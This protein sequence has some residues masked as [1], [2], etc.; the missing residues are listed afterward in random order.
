MA[1]STIPLALLTGLLFASPPPAPPLTV[2]LDGDG[3]AEQVTAVAKKKKARIEIRAAAGGKVLAEAELPAPKGKSAGVAEITLS[4]GSL[5]S[6]GA[7]LEAAA[8]SG[9]EECRSLWRYR[10]RALS[11]VPIASTAVAECGPAGEWSYGWDQGSGDAPAEYRRERT[12]QSAGGPNHRVESFRY[13]GFRLEPDPSRSRS[14][15]RGIAIPAWYAETIY[16]RSGLEGL[17]AHYDLSELKRSARLRILTDR[18]AGVFSVRIQ[19]PSSPQPE[20]V[21]PVTASRPGEEPNEVILTLGEDQPPIVLRVSLAG[22][23]GVPGE[24]RMTGAGP[25]LDVLYTPATLLA[26]GALHVF[27]TADDALASTFLVGSWSGPKGEPI[28]ISLASNDPVR[29]AVGGSAFS[30]DV[31]GAPD[32]VDAL[33]VPAAAGAKTPGVPVWGIVLRGPDSMD[34]VP[35][36]C[37]NA[38]PP[39]RCRVDGPGELF[40]RLGGRVNAH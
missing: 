28:T 17:Y 32:G 7:L 26:E 21:L 12:R 24:V 2:D 23:G 6:A 31:D 20:R 1:I 16:R 27:A 29:V 19:R 25:D 38:S 13:A 3:V 35:I 18:E 5:G 30:V 33:L 36:R 11:R 34:R 39:N 15:I 14:E 8:V 9:G 4:S 22:R 10:D 37:E 40:K